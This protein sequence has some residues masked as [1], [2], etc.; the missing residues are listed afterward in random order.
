[1]SNASQF[2]G[3]GGA[4]AGGPGAGPASL[5]AIVTTSFS[6]RTKRSGYIRFTGVGPGG[7]GAACAATGAGFIA[8][9]TGGGPGAFYR[10]VVF[11]P[12]GTLVAITIGAAGASVAANHSGPGG[13]G[14]PTDGQNG[15]N[16]IIQI[17]SNAPIVLQGGRGGKA[18]LTSGMILGGASGVVTGAAGYSAVPGSSG[19]YIVTSAVSTGGAFATGG[20]APNIL[21]YELGERMNVGHISTISTVNAAAGATGGGSPGGGS[22]PLLMSSNAVAEASGSG[23]MGGPGVGLAGGPDIFGGASDDPAVPANYATAMNPWKVMS[24]GGSGGVTGSS[25]GRQSAWGS[26][27][28]GASVYAA[29]AN[30]TAAAGDSGPFGGFGGAAA[31]S[32]GSN[33]TASVTMAGRTTGYGAGSGGAAA[34][35]STGS[36]SQANATS[37]PGGASIV[38]VEE[39]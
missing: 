36:S 7:S 29:S 1:M 5:L 34:K 32:G 15:G 25:V 2:L 21:G 10:D 22:P 33:T 18:S 3:S 12:A 37:A 28:G 6:F 38:V 16:T 4:S 8:Q 11:I 30:S 17:G 23:G 26:G 19:G 39:L 24:Q 35:R 14:T 13:G 27:S 9:A 31:F 20:G